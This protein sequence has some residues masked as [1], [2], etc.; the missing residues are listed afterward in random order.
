MN[1]EERKKRI[2][3][4]FETII[5]DDSKIDELEFVLTNLL[6]ENSSALN[7]KQYQQLERTIQQVNEG[8][9]KMLSWEEAKNELKLSF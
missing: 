1:V 3:K 7:E 4:Q 6:S 8:E 2:T 5:K 9:M